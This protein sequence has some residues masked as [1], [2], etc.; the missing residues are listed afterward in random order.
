M[1]NGTHGNYCN[2]ALEKAPEIFEGEETRTS[3]SPYA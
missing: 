1:I 3:S 2:E